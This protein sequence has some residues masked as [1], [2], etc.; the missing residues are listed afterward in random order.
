MLLVFKNAYE[1]RFHPKITN[2]FNYTSGNYEEMR[3]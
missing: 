2:A 3:M 1:S